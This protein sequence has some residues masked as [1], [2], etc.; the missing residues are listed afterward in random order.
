MAVIWDHEALC[1]RAERWLS[2]TRRCEP[3][4][5]NCASCGEIPDAIGWSSS[6]K[7]E[8]STVVECKTSRS[9]F[10]ADQ[11]KY[12]CWKHPKWGY[13]VRLREKEAK[14]LGYEPIIVPR[15]GDYRFYMCE[16]DIITPQ[17]VAD[18]APDH[19]LCYVHGKRVKVIVDAP[20]R[21]KVNKD[22]EIRYLR[23]AIIN[24]KT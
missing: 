24:K 20:K 21:E 14:E 15:M 12:R 6:Y 9:D 10:Y 22:G 17:M 5:S 2:G 19:G 11:A 4:F 16:P 3:V 8:G 13:S 23:F 7:Q 1:V 18:H